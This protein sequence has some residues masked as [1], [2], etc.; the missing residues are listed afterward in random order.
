[1]TLGL[2]TKSAVLFGVSMKSPVLSSTKVPMYPKVIKRTLLALGQNACVCE[3][4][5]FLRVFSHLAAGGSM[6]KGVRGIG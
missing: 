5:V 3:T 1:M 4:C 6:G 2:S